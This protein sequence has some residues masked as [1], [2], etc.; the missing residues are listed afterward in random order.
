MNVHHIGDNFTSLLYIA[1]TS[2]VFL[3]KLPIREGGPLTPPP[4]PLRFG[5]VRVRLGGVDKSPPPPPP[6]SSNISSTDFSA[7]RQYL[8]G[9]KIGVRGMGCPAPT[10]QAGRVTVSH[11][12]GRV[13]V[14][15]MRAGGKVA[16]CPHVT[17][18]WR[19]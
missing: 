9:G 1:V 6:H 10:P 5:G 8:V 12:G 4:P 13:R 7:D 14:G 18:I 19:C 15:G 17:W 11:G 16:P 3:Y 2:S